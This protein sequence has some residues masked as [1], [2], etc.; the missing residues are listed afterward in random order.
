MDLDRS[1]PASAIEL[2]TPIAEVRSSISP[3]T[4]GILHRDLYKYIQY[5]PN[6]IVDDQ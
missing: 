1:L 4:A 3:N 6:T 5:N 2:N